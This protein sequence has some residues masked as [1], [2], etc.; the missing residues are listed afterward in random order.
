MKL[1]DL[2]VFEHGQGR[3]IRL[4]SSKEGGIFLI[5]DPSVV[6][7]IK[8]KGSVIARHTPTWFLDVEDKVEVKI[9]DYHFFFVHTP[10]E[11]SRDPVP[12]EQSPPSG[13]KVCQGGSGKVQNDSHSALDLAGPCTWLPK[14]ELD[15]KDDKNT[16]LV[17]HA[18]NGTVC[19]RRVVTVH[20]NGSDWK[21]V[22]RAVIKYKS[23]QAHVCYHGGIS[24]LRTDISSQTLRRLQ[25]SFG[26][27]GSQVSFL[28][29]LGQV[30]SQTSKRRRNSRPGSVA[31][32]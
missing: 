5:I 23:L 26:G 25:I 10:T 32:H 30:I 21:S 13:A 18:S 8:V 2:A 20:G 17:Q 24:T 11:A 29:I 7:T 28:N 15:S 12:L 19:I 9:Q 6:A 31:M 27:T 22:A 14:A 4:Q 16:Q 3:L 1:R